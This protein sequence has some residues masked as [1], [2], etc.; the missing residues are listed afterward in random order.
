[1]LRD[2]PYLADHD[3]SVST[4]MAGQAEK[5]RTLGRL[6]HWA[7]M[8]WESETPTRLH[9]AEVWHDGEAS[10][11]LGAPQLSPSFRRYVE[12]RADEATYGLVAGAETWRDGQAYTRPM[13]A[14][15][16][17]IHGSRPHPTYT[18]ASH[19]LF[20]LACIGWSLEDV[21]A[22]RIVNGDDCRALP[23]IPT[24]IMVGYWH[25]ALSLWWD[26]FADG[27]PARE[28]A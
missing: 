1:M 11:A 16:W 8:T 28:V 13:H 24:D 23:P 5:P 27:P 3:R 12:G 25:W 18:P 9:V 17:R 6:L 14:A 22:R 21:S 10:S 19:R 20:A 4:R 26:R 15:L 2:R 7:K